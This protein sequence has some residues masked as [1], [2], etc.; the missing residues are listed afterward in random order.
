MKRL[1]TALLFVILIQLVSV[2]AFGQAPVKDY[3]SQWKIV[4]DHVKKKLPKSAL[5][6]VKKIYDQAK[7]EKQDAQ[8][9]KSLIYIMNLQE[10]NRENNYILSIKEFEKEIPGSKEPVTSILNSLLAEKYWSYYQNNRYKFFN[11]T[12]TVNFVKEDIAT[13]A[14]EDFYK[15]ISELFLASVANEKLLQQTRLDAYDAMLVKGNMRHLRPTLFDLLGNR[16]VAYFMNDERDVNKP[17][18]AFEIDQ[19]SAFDPAADFV[20]RKF[21][22]RD[23]LS[24]YQKALLLYQELIAFHLKDQKPD[25]L[26]DV[27]LAR[28]QFVRNKSV[29]PDKDQLYFNAINHI[30]RQYENLPAASQAWFLLASWYENQ[31]AQYKPYGDSTHRLDRVK[32]KEICDRILAQK[33]SS[34]GRINCYN[35]LQQIEMKQLQFEVEK[36]NV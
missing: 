27:D 20:T 15:K 17:A 14:A 33:D 19:A 10:E 3:A 4:E 11:R 13:W 1:K 30:A 24:L 29:H 25:A 8:V 26:I 16:A 36:V 9:I 2:T 18:Y 21:P 22:T 35:L 6:E 31:A 23:S 12:Q 32:A 34:E 7:K 5:T 28:I